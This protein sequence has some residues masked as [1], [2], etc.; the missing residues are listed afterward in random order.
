MVVLPFEGDDDNPQLASKIRQSFYS[1]F[2]PKKYHDVE[3]RDIDAMLDALDALSRQQW[4]SMSR[5][6][7]GQMF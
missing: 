4:R 7:A 3:P 5:A 2:S 1:H 6:G